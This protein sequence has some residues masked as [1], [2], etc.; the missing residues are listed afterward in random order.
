MADTHTHTHTHT[1]NIEIN[2]YLLILIA[3][4]IKANQPTINKIS[5]NLGIVILKSF[6]YIKQ[7]W[8]QQ[9]MT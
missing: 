1:S 6:W 7:K 8:N 3:I 4:V 5:H 9:H 2:I